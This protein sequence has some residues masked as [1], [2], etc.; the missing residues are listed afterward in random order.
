MLKSNIFWIRDKRFSIGLSVEY[1]ALCEIKS[2]YLYIFIYKDERIKK[3]WI[4]SRKILKE[5]WIQIEKLLK[6]KT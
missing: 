2:F 6:K 4:N 3:K 1:E 5:N